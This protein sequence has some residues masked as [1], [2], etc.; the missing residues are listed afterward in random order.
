MPTLDERFW[1]KVLVGDGCWDWQ[2]SKTP[3]GYGSFRAADRTVCAHRFSYELLVG[4]IPEGLDLD[5]LCRNKG[6]VNP[7]H[8]EPVTRRENML[9]APKIGPDRLI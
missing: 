1:A 4:P 6:C 5:H 2:A 3:G 7:E 9:R 8:L